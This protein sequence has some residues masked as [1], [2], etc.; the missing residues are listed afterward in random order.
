M[1]I[2]MIV[3][4]SIFF[5][6]FFVLK[7]K[8]RFLEQLIFNLFYEVYFIFSHCGLGSPLFIPLGG[9]R[10]KVW[11]KRKNEMRPF[12]GVKNILSKLFSKEENIY[13]NLFIHRFHTGSAAIKL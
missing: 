1:N 6:I 7:G 12:Y 10:G 4:I 8:I 11:K 5:K 13:L 3:S 2:L 9:V